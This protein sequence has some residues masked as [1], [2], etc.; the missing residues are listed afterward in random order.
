MIRFINFREIIRSFRR[1]SETG[2]LSILGLTIAITIA[3][4]IGFWSLNEFSF[5][6]FHA[7]YE[8]K[9][10]LCRKGFLNNESVIMGSE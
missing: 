4:L 3:L 10:R 5:D 6:K 8:N 7:N 9:Y 1:N 2:I